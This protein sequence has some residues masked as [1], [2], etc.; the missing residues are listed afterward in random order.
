MP[1]HARINFFN[2]MIFKSKNGYTLIEL[3]VAMGLFLIVLSIVSGLFIKSMNNQRAAVNL[4]EVN[5]SVSFS[6]EQMARE[7]RT[8]YYFCTKDYTITFPPYPGYP[9]CG[10]LGDNE[11]QFVNA[12]NQVVW[13]RLNNEA[14]ERGIE[15][16]STLTRTYTSITTTNVKVERFNIELIGNNLNDGYPPRIIISLSIAATEKNLKNFVINIQT[17]I[18]ARLLDS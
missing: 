18:S 1:D 9:D 15:D 2:K 3:L 16:P 13:Y 11:L 14:I 6:I 12:F 7:I 17:T 10:L 8:G 5:D 4:L